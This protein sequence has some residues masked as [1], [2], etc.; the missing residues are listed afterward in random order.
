[1]RVE[2]SNADGLVLRAAAPTADA[3]G[4]VALPVTI[5][6]LEPGA[7]VLRATATQGGNTATRETGLIVK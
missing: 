4:R 1:V 2:L 3:Q 5:A 6:G 7:Y